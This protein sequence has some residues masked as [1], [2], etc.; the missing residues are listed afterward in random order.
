MS[1]FQF[2]LLIGF[3]LGALIMFIADNDP[4]LSR[5]L[6]GAQSANRGATSFLGNLK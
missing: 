2:G 5:R 4:A 3:I 6:G 1:D